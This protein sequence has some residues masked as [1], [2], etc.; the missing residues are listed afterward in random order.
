MR[1]AHH[2][3]RA[4]MHDERLSG[5]RSRSGRWV[6]LSI[7]AG[8]P[9]DGAYSVF[10]LQHTC[11]SYKGKSEHPGAYISTRFASLPASS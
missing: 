10:E 11:T 8:N 2:G 4:R 5:P 6:C 7:D 9:G 3:C 1:K